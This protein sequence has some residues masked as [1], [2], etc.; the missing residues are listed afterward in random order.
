MTRCASLSALANR[1][2]FLTYL[3]DKMKVTLA[4]LLLLLFSN[5]LALTVNAQDTVTGAFEGNVTNSQ[6][7]DAIAGAVAEITNLETNITLTKRTDARGRFYQGLLAPGLYRIRVSAPNFGMREVIQRLTIARTGEVVPVP[8]SLDPVT[9][10]A[11]TPSVAAV[12]PP[13]TPAATP[14]TPPPTPAKAA[15][16][17]EIRAALNTTDAQRSGSFNELEVSALPLGGV[18]YTR[19][20]DELA[21]FL[22]GVAPPPQT[23]GSVAGPGQGAGVGTAGQFAVNGLR[24]R[25]NNFTVDGSDNNDEDIGVRRQGFT[26][27]VPQPIESVREYQTTTLLAPA[28]FG[29]NFGAIVNAVSKSGGS[30]VH[31]SLTGFFNSNKLNARNRFDTAQAPGSVPV[32]TASGQPV[33]LDNQPLSVPNGTAGKD[34]LTFSQ[35]G[36]TLGGPVRQG[37]TFYFL[38]FEG[39]KINASQEAQFAVPTVEQRGLF[40]SGATGVTQN[41]FTGATVNARPTSGGGNAFFSLFPFANQPGGAYGANTYAQVLPASARGTVASGK[42]DHQFKLADRSQSV[43]GRYNFTDDW[44]EI[45]QTGEAIFSTLRAATQTQNFSFFLNSQLSANNAP[46]ELLNQVRVSYGRTRLDFQ[47]V[48]PCTAAS[49]VYSND[50]LLPSDSFRQ[51]DFLLNRLVLNNLT[52]PGGSGPAYA[53]YLS[54]GNRPVTSESELGALGQLALAGFSPLGVDVYNFPQQRVNNTY[55]VADL[56]TWRA[57]N[58][59]AT[60]GADLRRTELN[61]NLPRLFRPLVTFNGA[62]ALRVVGTGST[63]RFEPVTSRNE[64]P[65][66]SPTDLAAT[67]VPNNFFLNVTNDVDDD[68]HINLR[69]YQL[70]FFAHDNWRVRPNLSLSL[71]LRYEYNTAPHESNDLIE[72]TF[73]DQTALNLVPG[74]RRFID[75]RTQIFEPERNNLAPRVSLAYTPHWFDKGGKGSRT[76]VLRAGAGLFYDQLLGAVVS[77]SRNV[78]PSFLNF[79]FGGLLSRNQTVELFYTNPTQLSAGNTP[80][81]SGLNRLN[82]PLSAALINLLNTLAPASLGLTLPTRR[83]ATPVAVQYNFAIEQQLNANLSLSFAYVGTQGRHLLRFTTPNLGPSTNIV[84]TSF[85]AAGGEPVVFGRVCAPSAVGSQLCQGRPEPGVGAVNIFET[86][87]NS[88]YNSLQFELRGRLQRGLQWQASYVYA[89]AEDDVSDVFDLAGASALPQNSF[90]LA[91]ERG[92][93]NFDLRHRATY[94]LLYDLSGLREQTAGLGWLVNGLQLASTARIQTG[95]PFTVNSI[96]DVNLDGNL[97][98]RLNS[99]EGLLSSGD[100]RQPLILQT[101]DLTRL[102]AT[103][104]QDG[105]VG[106][107]SFRAGGLMQIDLSLSKAFRFAATRSLS[108]RTDLFNLFNNANYGSP[109]RLLEAPS[110][111]RAVN[112]VTPGLRAQF[113]LKLEF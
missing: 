76:T 81:V 66:F 4:A 28:Q 51:T 19:T 57:G 30:A 29:R 23:L 105:S 22:P 8:V 88:G 59:S 69:F 91:A 43:T 80:L 89:K 26:A 78:F 41:P 99:V 39:Q 113:G 73:S 109:V 44:R 100:G 96:Y 16:A 55:Q 6:T 79:N 112:T 60:L 52:R 98:D 20:F 33:L 12:T 47:Q 7:G 18:T 31:G 15:A 36:A 102:L 94:T 110:F 24:S 84:P 3:K 82:V 9:T 53:R 2:I 25:A 5:A 111:G 86:S 40:G 64:A 10:T 103:A 106:R 107:N 42:L 63:A 46:R 58:H 71:G 97:T 95:Q 72:R 50:C 87:A 77:Q 32:R 45:G 13:L 17:N 49:G 92:P 108:L 83:L 70:N 75:G 65:F 38:A 27:L 35:F 14:P 68:A 34:S 37:T 104:G 62:P 56:L 74:L 101:T 85:L 1:Q 21:Q 54:E 11:I 61:S 90:N 67:G 93:A 48:R